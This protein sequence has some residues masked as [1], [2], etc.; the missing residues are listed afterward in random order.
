MRIWYD[1]EFHDNGETIDLISIG[2]VAED[3]REYYAVNADADWEAIVNH[4]WLVANVV[5]QLPPNSTWLPKATIRDQIR[6]FLLA[7]EEPELWAYFAAYDHVALSQLFGRMLDL[8]IGIPMFTNDLK[9]FM[10]R[11]RLNHVY[12]SQLPLQAS[13]Q[14]DALEDARH[15][16]NQWYATFNTDGTEKYP[17]VGHPNR[18]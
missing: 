10:Y 15:L 2:I 6:D 13:G 8:P 12:T 3:G 16:K 9:T 5:T 14:H 7:D 18:K 11:N 4:D 17:F 1:T